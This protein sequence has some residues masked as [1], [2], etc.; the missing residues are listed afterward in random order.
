[1]TRLKL[2]IW[3][4][5]I[6]ALN[7]CHCKPPQYKCEWFLGSTNKSWFHLWWSHRDIVRLCGAVLKS[8]IWVLRIQRIRKWRTNIYNSFSVFIARLIHKKRISSCHMSS[9]KST[10]KV[11]TLSDWKHEKHLMVMTPL[12]WKYSYLNV[13][14]AHWLENESLFLF[15]LTIDGGLSK[16]ILKWR[17]IHPAP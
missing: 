8:S 12:K 9:R 10:S 4:K 16:F 1:M 6:G 3:L 5:K 7:N 14:C 17:F 11:T 2:S 15:C 13:V